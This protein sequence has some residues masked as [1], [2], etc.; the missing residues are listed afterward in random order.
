MSKAG[1]GIRYAEVERETTETRVR[2]VLDLDGGTRQDVDTGI[3]FF[4]HM[5]TLLAF[6]GRI[7][8]GVSA[9]GDVHVD[10][11]HTVEDVGIVLGKALKDALKGDE[12]IARYGDNSTPMDETLVLCSL[13]FSGRGRFLKELPFKREKIGDMST[14]CVSEFFHALAQNAG[15]TLHLRCLTSENDH[16]LAEACFKAVGRAIFSATRTIDRRG[17]PST[18]GVID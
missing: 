13:D 4:D 3:H 6:H 16:H 8:I 17:A 2:V 15:L 7:D 10:D 1:K 12:P 9:E 18:K 14:E 5:L 11:H